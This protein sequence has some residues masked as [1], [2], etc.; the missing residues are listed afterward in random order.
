ME[1]GREGVVVNSSLK[2]FR[3][4]ICFARGWI[5]VLVFSNLFLAS[6]SDCYQPQNVD[7]TFFLTAIYLSLSPLL[8]FL[9]KISL[10]MDPDWLRIREAQ[11]ICFGAAAIGS[12]DA[13]ARF[14]G[15][16]ADTE[17]T[18]TPRMSEFFQKSNG[19]PF[20]WLHKVLLIKARSETIVA[21]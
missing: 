6:E 12:S 21:E 17:T 8:E 19:I 2:I 18:S 3:K 16:Q 5:L 7:L 1:Q 4:L 14:G 20:Y 11:S 13:F 9:P 10:P 15:S